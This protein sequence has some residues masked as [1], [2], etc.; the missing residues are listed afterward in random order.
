[1]VVTL[2]SPIYSVV[3]SASP[4]VFLKA[5][6]FEEVPDPGMELFMESK[7]EWMSGVKAPIQ[8]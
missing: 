2:G 5:G 4:M 6:L 8:K 3:P 7:L 1:M